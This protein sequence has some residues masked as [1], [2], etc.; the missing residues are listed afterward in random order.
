MLFFIIKYQNDNLQCNKYV[1]QVIQLF[2]LL[3]LPNYLGSTSLVLHFHINSIV[4]ILLTYICP[5]PITL[6]Y[7]LPPLFRLSFSH[8]PSIFIPF[9][10]ITIFVSSLFKTFQHC[11]INLFSLNLSSTKYLLY[12][13]YKIF[14]YNNY[15]L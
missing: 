3:L 2:Y 11:H 9:T 12:F 13:Y 7:I 15:F 14:F 6:Y 10:L 5:L 8:F 1:Y 4:C